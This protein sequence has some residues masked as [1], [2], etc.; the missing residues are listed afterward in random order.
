VSRRWLLL[1]FLLLPLS[2]HAD[3]LVDPMRPNGTGA[4]PVRARA[5]QWRVESILV[6]ASRRVAVVNGQA[7]AIGD[8]VGGA[9][10]VAIEP[11][12]VELEFQGTR[13]RVQLAAIRV[14]RPADSNGDR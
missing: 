3:E 11:Y 7:V 5:P 1:P 9:R 14:T 6:S 2:L 13:H 8:R 12:E 4:A 10:V